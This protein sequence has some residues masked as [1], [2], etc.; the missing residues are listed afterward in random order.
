MAHPEDETYSLIFRSLRHPIRRKI[1][2][3][4]SESPH[5]FSEMQEV[6]KIESPHLT[7]HLE[8]LNNLLSKTE[9]AKYCLSSF[10]K[11]AVDVMSDIEELPKPAT[12]LQFSPNR[13]KALSAVLLVG[14]ILLSGLCY[15]Q[16]RTV[17]QLSDQ[18]LSLKEQH[19]DLQ[20]LLREILGIGNA[21]LTQEYS[22]NGTVATALMVVNETDGWVWLSEERL[23]GHNVDWYGI[24]SLADNST[25]EIEISLTGSDLPAG[26]Y[27]N[28][29]GWKET[30]N[31]SSDLI[32]ETP[33]GKITMLDVF[34]L[35][36]WERVNKSATYLETLP[37]RGFYRIQVVAPDVWNMT[38]HY[39]MN[40][41]MTLRVRA[42]EN[43]IPFFAENRTQGFRLRVT[44]DFFDEYP[45]PPAIGD[46]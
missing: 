30:G 5:G 18:Y 27:L 35:G 20:Q 7:Y 14:M 42:Q 31:W 41:A 16:Y 1:L 3:L 17:T 32:N 24:Y 33:A 25:L 43:Q 12:H 26:A 46:P 38:N 4:L 23:W 9:D 21:V 34:G 40:Y 10:G 15:L 11:A 36:F 45:W 37:S 6:L 2:R 28:I 13:W 39:I 44:A 29:M 19:N 22:E 8:S